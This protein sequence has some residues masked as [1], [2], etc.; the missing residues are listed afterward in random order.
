MAHL[1]SDLMLRNLSLLLLLSTPAVPQE[2][3][4][5][6]LSG[7]SLSLGGEVLF[8]GELRTNA[9]QATGLGGSEDAFLTRAAVDFD[10]EFHRYLRGYLEMFGAVTATGT[11]DVEDVEQLY[12][13]FD[14]FLGDYSLRVGRMQFDLGDGRVISSIP[15][16]VERNTF[17]G[18]QI[19]S[20][21]RGWD[22]RAWHTK[23]AGGPS[24]FYD[25]TF[26]GI[27]GT[28]HPSKDSVVDAFLLRRGRAVGDIE[29]YTVGL[30]WQGE[31]RNGFEWNVFGAYQDGDDGIREI[32]S[33][34]VAITLRKQLDYG[35][36]VGVEMALAKG[37]DGKPLDRKRYDPVYID[38][39]VYNGR[40][41]IVAFS[42]L[43]DLA[44]MYWLDWN[45]RWSFHVDG[46]EFTRQNTSDS[47]YLGYNV[48]PVTPASSSGGIGRELD[49]YCEGVLSDNFAVDFGGAIFSPQASLPHDQ[50]Q[51]WLY[52]QFVLNF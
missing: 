30:R 23:T 24:S 2:P 48:T 27:Y 16:L 18:V 29:E 25:E 47:V 4:T 40:A 11:A 49:I 22:L 32:L 9:D 52:I 26:S 28:T 10:F 8:R 45:E 1:I 46:H 14:Q 39:H 19:H 7:V 34:A 41:D 36:G 50:E 33:Q 12:L 31:T 15:W 38:Q 17:D 43:L 42:N 20:Q 51:L 3:V 6:G 37:N 5:H 44:V 21:P 35:H 13:D